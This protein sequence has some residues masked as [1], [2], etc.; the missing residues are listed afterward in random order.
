[1]TLMKLQ[2]EIAECRGVAGA[3]GLAGLLKE[4]AEPFD[5][6]A[7]GFLRGEPNRQELEY[8]P[9]RIDLFD[10]L[11]CD[12]R[13]EIA[14]VRQIADQALPLERCQRFVDGRGGQIEAVGERRDDQFRA[15]REDAGN[16]LAA[17]GLVRAFAQRRPFHGVVHDT[18]GRRNLGM[19]DNQ[20]L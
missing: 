6:G 13:Y 14:A 19:I 3:N 8:F 11:G 15:G 9:D 17:D 5:G 18:S 10:V 2:V 16:D 1:M 4:R 7:I 12:R 20:I